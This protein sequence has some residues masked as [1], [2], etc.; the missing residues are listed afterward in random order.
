MVG[1]SRE[2]VLITVRVLRDFE[3][4]NSFK[5]DSEDTHGIR[6]PVLIAVFVCTVQIFKRQNWA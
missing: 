1:P 2:A 5:T 4:G 3:F 6:L